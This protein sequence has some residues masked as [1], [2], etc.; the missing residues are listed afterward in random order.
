MACQGVSARLLV[1]SPH[2]KPGEQTSWRLSSRAAVFA[3]EF[4]NKDMLRLLSI[5]QRYTGG[6]S[7]TSNLRLTWFCLE[8]KCFFTLHYRN[9][10]LQV[11]RL[12]PVHANE[13]PPLEFCN[14]RKSVEKQ[15]APM[16]GSRN[17]GRSD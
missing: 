5:V 12:V 7:L 16:E 6:S 8:T 15:D 17:A 11:F 2:Q 1:A 13:A 10:G 9:P 14:P 3:K 4:C